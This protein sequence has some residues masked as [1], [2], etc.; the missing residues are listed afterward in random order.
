MVR[1]IARWVDGTAVYEP[2]DS[3]PCSIFASKSSL[4]SV[5]MFV[6]I[7]L[8]A[9]TSLLTL[10]SAKQKWHPKYPCYPH[11]PRPKT[12]VVRSGYDSSNGTAD[13]SPAIAAAF[14]KCASDSVI[15][16]SEGVEYNVFTPIVATNLSNVEIQMEGNL[17]LPQNISYIQIFVNATSSGTLYWFTFAGPNIDY[18]G[19]SNVTNGWMESYGQPW[20]DANPVNGT[21]TAGR[22]HLISFNT[23]NGGMQHFKSRKPIAWSLTLTGTNVT[24]TDTVVDAYSVSGSFPF[25]TDGKPFW[26]LQGVKSF[27]LKCYLGDPHPECHET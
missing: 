12:C 8:L 24:V 18:V 23:T 7:T 15:T 21:G 6:S 10:S 2:A 14:A 26:T 19:T 17:N 11:P 13:D 4:F 20:W 3:H 16:F 27:P 25:N 9:L 1:K 22:P 5:G